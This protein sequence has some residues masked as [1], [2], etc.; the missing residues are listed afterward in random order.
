MIQGCFREYAKDFIRGMRLRAGLR[1]MKSKNSG[2]R[3]SEFLE[4]TMRI[5]KEEKEFLE[6]IG[7]L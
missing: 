2:V 5:L 1:V 7:M 4:V 6:K 3:D